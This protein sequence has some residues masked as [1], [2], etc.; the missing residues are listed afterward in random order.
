MKTNVGHYFELELKKALGLLL[1]IQWTS[2]TP[3]I[4]IYS[5]IAAWLGAVWLA[6]VYVCRVVRSHRRQQDTRIAQS[7]RSISVIFL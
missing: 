2:H 4:R 7:E 6:L 5:P 3:D 1:I